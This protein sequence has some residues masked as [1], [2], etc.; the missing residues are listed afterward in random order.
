MS[1]IEV[2]FEQVKGLELMKGSKLYTEH[3]KKLHEA[4]EEALLALEQKDNQ[5]KWLISCLKT[6][7]DLCKELREKDL[8][9]YNKYI[10]IE[11]DFIYLS[12]ERLGLNK[13]EI[14]KMVGEQK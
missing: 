12:L 8:D 4:L 2:L 13:S 1:A 9:H 3:S 11:I 6:R 10:D 5:V 14:R 7:L